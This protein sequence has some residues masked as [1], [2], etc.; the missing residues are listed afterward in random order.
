MNNPMNI[1]FVKGESD[2]AI[3]L[4]NSNQF[5]LPDNTEMCLAAIWLNR[6]VLLPNGEKH[7]RITDGMILKIEND[8]IV[9]S[10]DKKATHKIIGCYGTI[11]SSLLYINVIDLETL[12]LSQIKLKG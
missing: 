9:D 7:Q 12:H 11:D 4:R 3:I 6:S 1:N 8:S 2:M 10:T 5:N